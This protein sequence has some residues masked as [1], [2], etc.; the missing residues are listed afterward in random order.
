MTDWQHVGVRAVVEVYLSAMVRASQ[1]SK[2]EALRGVPLFAGLS[3]NEL[4]ALARL[5]DEAELEA[6]ASLFREGEISNEFF[7]ILDGNAEVSRAGTHLLNMGPGDFL[8]D[9]SLVVGSR[10]TA[11]AQATT[12]MRVFVMTRP[13]FVAFLKATPGV[14]LKVLRSMAVRLVAMSD[15][16]TL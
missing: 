14:E 13:D 15:V 1:S 12:A 11:S 4:V 8:G 10:R 7:V 3:R 16:P 9:V 6:G 5:T 2:V